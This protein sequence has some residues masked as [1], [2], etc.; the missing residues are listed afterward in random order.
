MSSFDEW[1]Q[2]YQDA[3][4]FP[5]QIEDLGCP[6]CGS[7]ELRLRFVEYDVSNPVGYAAFWCNNCLRGIVVD[8]TVVPSGGICASRDSGEIPNYE[9][10]APLLFGGPTSWPGPSVKAGYR[11]SPGCAIIREWIL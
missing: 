1:L 3:Y 5:R 4:D 8:R 2:V 9:I 7:N 6:R 11:A 10:V